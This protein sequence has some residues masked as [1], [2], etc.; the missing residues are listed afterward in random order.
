MICLQMTLT[1][2][3]PKVNVSAK[4]FNPVYVP[5]LKNE[6]HTQIFFGGSSSG[7][8]YFLAQRCVLDLLN[9]RN[10]LALRNV[11]GTIRRSVW[12]ELNKAI[13]RM[14]LRD[15]FDVSKGELSIMAVNN[16]AQLLTAGLDDVEKIKSITP[17]RG[18]LT[19]IWIEEATEI[20]YDDYKQ[21]TKRLR[22]RADHPKRI[23]LSFN[24]VFKEHWL[25]KEFFGNWDEA[26]REY[27]SDRLSIL[28]TTYTDNAF[29]TSDDIR[30]LENETD[31]Y[32]HNVYTLGNWGVIGDVVFRNWRVED[33][34]ELKKTCDKPMY[35]LDFGFSSDP[36]AAVKVH[37]DRARKTV[38]IL[39]ELYE[40]GLTNSM[41]AGIMLRFAGNDYITCDSA[42]PKS[43]KELQNYG[44]RA[45]SAKK[46]PDS[47]EHGIQWLQGCTI[48]IDVRCANAKQ[49]IQ[50]YQWAKDK[51]G[52]SLRVPQSKDDH[53]I[54]A[55]RYCM[56]DESTARYA[57][58]V[59]LRGL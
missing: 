12:N 28:K 16:G 50:L 20:S 21:L 52:N 47:V 46:G 6:A 2:K 39:E 57:G 33:L 34:T 44:V 13:I 30:E 17:F 58:T 51:Y 59:N 3:T 54:D 37:Y 22:G 25:Y 53:I 27:A 29:L 18:V 38:Y 49:E 11:A 45:K 48:V 41:L 23:T 24:P 26:K 14:G 36:C 40:R 9:G 19:D 31:E 42:E 32:Y 55:L 35:G 10:I 4:L 8:S 56:E 43:I 15:W 1:M 7:K 5:H